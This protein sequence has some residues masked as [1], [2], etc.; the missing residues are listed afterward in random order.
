MENNT[1]IQE[2]KNWVK[3][4]VIGLNFC[5]FAAKEFDNNTIRY[6]V[7]HETLQKILLQKLEEEYKLLDENEAIE[8]TLL[9]LPKGYESF[10]KFL[11]LVNKVE[12]HLVKTDY[13]GIYQIANFHPDYL[14]ADSDE[15]DAA[16]YTNRS[17]YPMLHILREASLDEVLMN[18]S[19]P[20][21]IPNRNISVARK[22][23]LAFMQQL[24]SSC[25]M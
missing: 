17:L 11:S 19:D 23:G 5:P 12:N 7:I 22:K 14:F 3:E 1:I 8:T 6:E 18:Y 10:D 13:E 9:I 2:T 25:K 4:V 16:N 20:E 21:K 15:N 24:R